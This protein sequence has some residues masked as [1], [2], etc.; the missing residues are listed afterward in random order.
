M[1]HIREHPHIKVII[2]SNS[3][4][5]STSTQQGLVKVG[6]EGNSID[7]IIT[8]GEIGWQKIKSRQ[9][10]FFPREDRLLRVSVFG[11]A[12]DDETYLESCR[13][14]LADP[15][16][17]DF[18]LARG[19]FCFTTASSCHVYK[20]ADELFIDIETY[21][22][23]CAKY[24]IPMLV[25]NPDTNRPGSNAPMPGQIGERYSRRGMRVEYIGK[26]YSS[27]YHACFRVAE[28]L[29]G[30]PA[31]SLRFCAIGDSL[32]HDIRGAEHAG[33]DSV[34]VMNGVHCLALGREEGSP[35]PPENKKVEALLER[36]DSN[37]T[38]SLP[39]FKW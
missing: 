6:L 39:C 24:N 7:G 37:P 32:E 3:S 23:E 22:D 10:D 5:R 26:P 17:A 25:T 9:Y 30:K 34:W 15:K 19:S 16:D 14:T 8:S 35:D 18:I 38:Y 33:M 2:L 36:F 31:G 11:N 29:T 20:N 1:R 13:C 28:A 4:K 12:D 27:V 21:L